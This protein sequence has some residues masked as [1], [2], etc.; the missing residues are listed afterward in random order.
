MGIL[1]SAAAA[2]SYDAVAHRFSQAASDYQSH[3]VV[4]RQS[5]AQLLQLLKPTVERLLD[6]GAGP[7]TD[8]SALSP[9][10]VIAVDIA[11]GM[12][13]QLRQSYECYQP[14]CADAQQ[15]PLSNDSLDG[16]FSNLALQWCAS[17]AQVAGEAYRVLRPQGQL[18]IAIVVDGSLPELTELG[19]QKR[20]FYSAE[21]WQQAFAGQ[22]WQTLTS[23]KQQH[24]CYFDD[25]R[26]LLYSIKGVGASSVTTNAGLRGKRYWQQLEQ[27]A[28]ALRQPQGLALSYQILYL[29]A[30]K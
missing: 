9:T 24:H 6:V 11:Q 1:K 16:Y 3:D 17:M 27:Q 25:L 13:S 12:L 29:Q 14:I 20:A 19:L 23:T 30:Q 21:M 18:A 28:Q 2:N 7:G 22:P 8:F 4:Q 15:L 26:S 10:Q 5:R